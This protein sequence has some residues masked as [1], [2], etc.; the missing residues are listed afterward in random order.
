MQRAYAERRWYP[1]LAFDDPSLLRF[2]RR[3]WNFDPV[4]YL[5]RCRCSLLA[6]WG[7]DDVFV[8]AAESRKIFEKALAK[9][10]DVQYRLVVIPGLGHGLGAEENGRMRPD[11]LELMTRWV[12]S[13]CGVDLERATPGQR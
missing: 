12:M 11:V 6:V 7:E 4:P 5:E 1:Y 8:A 2:V 9:G 3:I 13:V 10:G